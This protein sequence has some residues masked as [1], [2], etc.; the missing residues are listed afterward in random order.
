MRKFIHSDFEL[1]LSA[2][3]ITDNEENPWL[4]G[5][6]FTKYSYPFTMELTDATDAMLNMI[7]NYNAAGAETI[8]EGIYVDG[9]TLEQAVLEIGEIE[10]TVSLTLRYG[11]DDF[12]NF[13]KKLSELPLL[14]Q[15]VDDIYEHAAE[16]I[17][18]Q[19]PEV[20]YN[21]PQV[22]IDKIDTDESE[23]WYAFNKIINNYIN[24]AF[25]VNDVD[26][27][28]EETFNRN[29]MQP[30]PYLLYIIKAGIEAAGFT[31]HGDILSDPVLQK[32]LLYADCEYYTSI[33]QDSLELMALSDQYD[34]ITNVGIQGYSMTLTRQL[35]IT[36]PGKYRITGSIYLR[37]FSQSPSVW[38]K[39]YY[40]DQLIGEK[41][42]QDT[43]S[44]YRTWNVDI[45]FETLDDGQPDFLLFDLFARYLED[46]IIF[47]IQ[48]NP[49]ILHDVEG[50]IIPSI[51]NL[52]Q[53]NI[54]RAV[55]EMTFGE[56]IKAVL[57]M[58]NMYM[59]KNGT[60]VSINYIQT[61]L[62]T[63]AVR[64][65]SEFEVRFPKRKFNKGN[66][67]LLK[68]QDANSDV[69]TYAEV[70][71][72]Y[73]GSVTAGYTR[74]DK[75]T[76]IEINALPLPLL[77]RSGVQTAHGFLEDKSKPFFV[78]YN[79]LVGGLNLSVDPSQLLIPYLH[80][81]YH[82]Q[83]LE[84]R[85]NSQ[86]FTWTFKAH[87]EK[88]IGLTARSRIHAYTNIHLVKNY[89]KTQVAPDQYE[90]EIESVVL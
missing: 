55:P 68:Y 44:H 38:S 31:L 70:F 59:E 10:K 21:F 88:L 82:K 53:V 18:K 15:E 76:D 63:A 57:A 33:S 71:Q 25:L 19:W 60:Q 39:I 46:E 48:V 4:S 43:A 54:P 36:Q 26:I 47:D 42:I 28:T 45:V 22:H 56:L 1:D 75:T 14:L 27:E 20:N 11:L 84:K 9:D 6:Y 85:I 12:P 79:G 89:Q 67:F 80:E 77:F 66:S 50:N 32:T 87:Y 3:Q 81:N 23:V 52:N 65:L 61:Q 24:G 2:Y 69:Y 30:L 74:D 58:K 62:L 40:R 64:D 51:L 17:T 49:I 78:L 34:S 35:E 5:N 83:W 90:V 37:T 72:N 73:E 7:G 16:V 29:I 86:T 8:F 41:T 13:G